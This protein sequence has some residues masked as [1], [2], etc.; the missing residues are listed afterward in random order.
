MSLIDKVSTVLRAAAAEAILPRF[1]NLTTHD[2]EEK[3]PGELVTAAD[4][5]AE[6]LIGA[7]CCCSIHPPGSWARKLAHGTPPWLTL[8][9]RAPSG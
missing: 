9:I 6:R 7:H 8:S 5:H 1:R 4:L 2:V 3:S